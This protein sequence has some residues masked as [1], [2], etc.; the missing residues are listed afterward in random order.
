MTF[1]CIII[2]QKWKLQWAVW[3]VHIA[4]VQL[5]P[6]KVVL[7]QILGLQVGPRL[8]PFLLVDPVRVNDEGARAK[9]GA[10]LGAGCPRTPCWRGCHEHA[11]CAKRDLGIA[12]NACIC[13]L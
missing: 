4:H 10:R 3:W 7:G 2:G 6:D 13:S 12:P 5:Q 9:N 11:P 8:D 1:C